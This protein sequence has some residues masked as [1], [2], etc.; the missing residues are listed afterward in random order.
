[1]H[2]LEVS[3]ELP[4]VDN[5]SSLVNHNELSLW[6]YGNLIP[7]SEKPVTMGE[8][9]TPLVP[10][11]EESSEIHFKLEYVS[12][13]GSFKDRGA[14]VGVTRARDLGVKRLV[15]DSSGNAGVAYAVYSASAGVKARIY[16]PN[17]APLAKRELLRKCG[18]QVVEC[19]TREAASQKAIAELEEG[20]LYVGHTWDPFFIEGVKSEVYELFEFA[21]LNY[22]S[23][24]IPVSSGTHILGFYKGLKELISLGLIDRIPRIYGVQ[25]GGCTP[26]YDAFHG[27]KWIGERGS[28]ADGLRVI[29]PPRIQ[30]IVNAIRDSGG[31]VV[32]VGNK[33]ISIAMKQ[34]YQMGFVVEPTSATAYA[35]YETIKREAGLKTLIPLTGSGLKTLDR[36]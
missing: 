18:A 19:K 12:P 27:E 28:L 5:F 35:A 11:H 30:I 14:V 15:E 8:G 22:D 34:L 10:K 3:V 23:V 7:F 24:V 9:M 4:R 1:M 13:T 17:D 29:D 2:P 36:L 31:S 26:V 16:V 21:S 32:V 25:A 20:D 33:E 6:R